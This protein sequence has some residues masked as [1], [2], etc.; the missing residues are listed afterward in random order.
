MISRAVLRAAT[1]DDAP[2]LAALLVRTWRARY[3]GLVAPDVLDGLDEAGFARWFAEVLSPGT[4]H[5]AIV[6]SAGAA[7]TG[8]IH[9]GA[10][11]DDPARGHVFSFYVAPS[12]SGRG[13]GRAL[14]EGALSELTARGHR[15][16]TLWVFKANAPTVRLYERAG[17]RADGTER[18]EPE[19]G[20]LEQ[21]MRLELDRS[22]AWRRL[23]D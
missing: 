22:D 9:L 19:F 14:L 16:V 7:V 10:D 8:F 23:T 11:E 12:H 20:V 5:A 13:T 3:P 21:R 15:V 6:S 18:V 4:G 2:A 1:R 17:F